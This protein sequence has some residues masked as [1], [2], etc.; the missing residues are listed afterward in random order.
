LFYQGG[1]RR[2]TETLSWKYLLSWIPGIPLAI[3]NGLLRE[4]VYRRFLTELS[5]QQV[6]ALSFIVL[7]GIYVWLIDRW[8][9]L[10]S[11][12]EALRVGLTWLAL[13]VAFEFLFGHYV[14]GQP[15]E[16]LGHDY[17]LL[18]GRLWVLVLVWITLSPLALYLLRD[19]PTISWEDRT[20]RLNA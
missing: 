4:S 14:M 19:R 1:N 8:L 16:R 20:N 6:S 11:S 5:A 12:K 18:A 2:D 3:V 9:R 13:T 7:F 10:S 17:N 15:W